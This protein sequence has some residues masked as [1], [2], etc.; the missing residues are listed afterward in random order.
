LKPQKKKEKM[1]P[2][3][4]LAVCIP[5]AATTVLRAWSD[6]IRNNVDYPKGT[7]F[8]KTTGLPVASARNQMIAT[9]NDLDCTHILFVDD[10]IWPLKRNAVH[11]LLK[12]DLALIGGLCKFRTEKN[13]W[14]IYPKELQQGQ[15]LTE[16]EA[17][18]GGFLL[19]KM[20]VFNDIAGGIPF[21]Q[22]DFF[23]WSGSTYKPTSEDISFCRLAKTYGHRIYIDR[24]V[25]CGHHDF[26]LYDNSEKGFR[27]IRNG[28]KNSPAKV[29]FFQIN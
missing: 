11:S 14:V 17:T 20:E 1:K 25:R 27:N 28:L 10:D 23:R 12:H 19:V 2:D 6:H 16:V 15:G 9:A 18:G 24:D 26:I 3:I 21:D 29:D 8:L 7:Y 13:M 22:V 5:S 4:K